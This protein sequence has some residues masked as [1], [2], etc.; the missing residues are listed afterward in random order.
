MEAIVQVIGDIALY[1][2]S[3]QTALVL[4]TQARPQALPQRRERACLHMLYFPRKF[5]SCISM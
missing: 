3:K 4:V 1:R 2:S 5:G